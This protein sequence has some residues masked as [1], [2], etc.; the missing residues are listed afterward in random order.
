MTYIAIVDLRLKPDD[1]EGA[2][3]AVTSLLEGT[4]GFDGNKGVD[5]LIDEADPTH[6]MFVETWESAEH[7]AAYSAWRA[8][9]GKNGALAPFVAGPPTPSKYRVSG[10]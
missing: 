1:L 5:V 2:G 4:R 7:S 8:G 6:W 3:A 9:E 10:Y